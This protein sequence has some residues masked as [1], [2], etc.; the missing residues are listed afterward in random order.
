M[1]QSANAFIGFSEHIASS[2]PF[3]LDMSGHG[4]KWWKSMFELDQ[5]K[6]LAAIDTPVLIIQSQRDENV[7]PELAEIQAATLQKTKTNITYKPYA[8]LDHGFR[9][10]D[11][12]RDADKVI[13]DIKQWLQQH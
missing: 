2:E 5:T 4:F 7:S 8:N 9:R 6:T 3:E 11:G 12:V 10:P 13:E 1:I